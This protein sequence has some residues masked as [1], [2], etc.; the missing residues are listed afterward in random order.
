MAVNK[1]RKHMSRQKGQ[2]YYQNRQNLKWSP[3]SYRLHSPLIKPDEKDL[4]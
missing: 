3:Q 1:D 4:I 2:N